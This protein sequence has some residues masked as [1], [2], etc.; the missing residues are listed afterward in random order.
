MNKFHVFLLVWFPL[1]LFS[2]W[3]KQRVVDFLTSSHKKD[4][5]FEVVELKNDLDEKSPFYFRS[6][7]QK[8]VKFLF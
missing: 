7:F 1:V 5:D 3:M 2:N 6:F 8:Y 4:E